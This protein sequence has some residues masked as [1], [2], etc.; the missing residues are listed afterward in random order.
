M[1]SSPAVGGVRVFVGH[2]LR[3]V[4]DIS[5]SGTQPRWELDQAALYLLPT[6]PVPPPRHEHMVAFPAVCSPLGMEDRCLEKYPGQ[7]AGSPA[8]DTFWRPQLQSSHF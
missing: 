4:D 2:Q 5:S 8:L 6:Q 7:A 1:E 3:H